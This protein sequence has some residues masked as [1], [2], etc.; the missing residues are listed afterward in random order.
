[1]PIN[2]PLKLRL[3]KVLNEIGG[4]PGNNMGAGLWPKANGS[5][6]WVMSG[7]L[8]WWET[9]HYSD[10]RA[11][12]PLIIIPL[13]IYFCDW[14]GTRC[15]LSL[16]VLNSTLVMNPG[17][18]AFTIPMVANLWRSLQKKIYG[19]AMTVFQ[20]FWQTKLS[21]E[22]FFIPWSLTAVASSTP[23]Q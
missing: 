6:K 10:S 23:S 3:L 21:L 19:S 20:C 14:E 15:S 17:D 11:S 5:V 1:M 7:S 9:V 13:V 18:V 16:P 2:Q 8:K 4:L 22:E 12:P